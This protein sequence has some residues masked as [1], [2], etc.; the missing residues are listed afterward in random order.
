MHILHT[1][2]RQAATASLGGLLLLLGRLLLSWLLFSC[3]LALFRRRRLCF[4]LFLLLL[5]H[6]GHDRPGCASFRFGRLRLGERGCDG[7]YDEFLFAVITEPSA[8][9]MSPK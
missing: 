5:D 3:F 9:L 7:E 6:L 2:G 1:N 4:A 8:A